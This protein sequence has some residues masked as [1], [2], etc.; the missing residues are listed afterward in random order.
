[1]TIH[2]CPFPDTPHPLNLLHP[3]QGLKLRFRLGALM[4]RY[5][6]AKEDVYSPGI[7]VQLKQYAYRSWCREA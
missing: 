6:P 5:S 2:V 1:M 3:Q 7:Y 4:R